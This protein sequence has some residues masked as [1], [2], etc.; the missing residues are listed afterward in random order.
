MRRP[1]SARKNTMS[2]FI[3]DFFSAV[4]PSMPFPKAPKG[5]VSEP[6]YRTVVGGSA[7]ALRQTDRGLLTT[8]RLGVRNASGTTAAIRQLAYSSPDMSAAIFAM[9]RTG[10]HERY[11]IVARDMDGKINPTAT[12]TA[13]ELL[14]RLTYLGNADGSYGAQMSLQSLSES[15]G[16]ELLIYGAC[17]GEVALDKQRIPASLNAITVSK[18][19]WYDEDKAMR[20]VQVV[21]GE[22]IDLDIPTF[23]YVSL[24]QDLLEPYAAS[25]LEAA[26]QPLLQDLEFSNDVRRAL[27]RSVLP[28]LTATIDSEAVRKSTPPDIALDPVKYAQYKNDI[29]GAIQGVINGAQPEDALISFSEVTYAYIDGGKDPSAII[30]RLQKVI[31][32]KLQ[33]GTKTLP[34]VVGQGQGANSSSAESLLFVKSANMLRLKL[35]EFY[36]RSLTV[37]L[38][39]M[40]E[41][42]YVEFTYANI[43]LRPESELEAYRA[44]EQSRVLELLSLGFL[45]DEEASVRLTGNL[46]PAGFKPLSGTMFK[47]GSSTASA[48]NGTAA[49]QTSA[50]DKTLNSPT[51]KEPKSANKAEVTPEMLAQ[52][53]DS[54]LAAMQ[55]MAY[56]MSKQGSKPV[57][58]SVAPSEMQLT[59]VQE[60]TK[61][62]KGYKVV[63]D[64][65]GVFLRIEKIEDEEAA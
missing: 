46:P 12:G 18:L 21:G 39:V 3:Q 11:T 16:R 31:N 57:E 6:G 61:Q 54:S 25:P 9:L 48:Q 52:M 5:G 15:L 10:I 42:C 43:D 56:A 8:D 58:V 62:A 44:M 7:S 45:T 30:E 55:D 36:S 19:K 23:V 1:D 27:K 26:I 38:R 35:N 50:M 24:D 4:L 17:S 37:A 2:N 22:E 65:A 64:E 40:G 49:S 29:I 34:I 28:R 47:Q 32:A 33:A 20:P 53:H 13:Q 59:L 41:D 14:R 60:P 51:P 63:R